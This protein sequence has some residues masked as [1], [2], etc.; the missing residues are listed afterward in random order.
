MMADVDIEEAGG[1]EWLVDAAIS[2]AL[3]VFAGLMSGLTLGLMSLDVVDLEVLQRSGTAT[4]K[5]QA[6]AFASFGGVVLLSLCFD[7]E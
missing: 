4:E 2:F 3:V 1:A 6:G 5:K 7:I